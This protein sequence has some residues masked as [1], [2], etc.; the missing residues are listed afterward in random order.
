MY[1]LTTEVHSR[2]SSHPR[3]SD[4]QCSPTRSRWR[5]RSLR[6]KVDTWMRMWTGQKHIFTT[7]VVVVKNANFHLSIKRTVKRPR[8]G[9]RRG[10]AGCASLSS[11]V[12]F[13]KCRKG[14]D[15]GQPSGQLLREGLTDAFKEPREGE[16]RPGRA[17]LRKL[18]L[19]RA[20]A[21]ARLLTVCN[22]SVVE[23]CA[24]ARLT[25]MHWL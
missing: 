6:Q 8:V 4:S 10:R 5:G 17:A 7:G 12:S 16:R 15:A 25:L 22:A 11:L 18:P 23:A 13:T 24:A 3:H 19:K 14:A 2:W 20:F 21:D 9:R 1:I